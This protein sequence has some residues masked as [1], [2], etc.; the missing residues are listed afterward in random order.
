MEDG[1]HETGWGAGGAGWGSATPPA[2]ESCPKRERHE[3]T[4]RLTRQPAR[5]LPFRA[6]IDSHFAKE[7]SFATMLTRA[8][9]RPRCPDAITA[10]WSLQGESSNNLAIFDRATIRLASK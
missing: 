9:S 5:P 1:W 6:A 10:H 8:I 4:M 2:I 3:M 7:S